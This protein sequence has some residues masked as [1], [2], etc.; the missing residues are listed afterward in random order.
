MMWNET[1]L[2]AIATILFMIAGIL[3][4]GYALRTA[5]HRTCRKLGWEGSTIREAQLARELFELRIRE[6]CAV[7]DAK[8]A[9]KTGEENRNGQE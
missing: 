2:T 7:E 5:W 3:M 8:A 4:V 1:T 9:F 6:Q